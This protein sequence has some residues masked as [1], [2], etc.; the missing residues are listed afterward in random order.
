MSEPIL[1]CDGGRDDY[2]EIVRWPPVFDNQE[3]EIVAVYQ[4]GDKDG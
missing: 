2:Y 3:G 1:C 4:S